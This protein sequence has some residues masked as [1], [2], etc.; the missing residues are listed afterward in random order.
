[1]KKITL[2]VFALA[3]LMS[4]AQEA[5]K[6]KEDTKLHIGANLQS[7]GTGLV[8]GMD[9]GLGENI[10]VGF[11]GNYLLGAT[12]ILGEK[13]DFK[14][15]VD[16]RARFN[17]NLGKVMNLPEQIDVYPGLDLGLKNF[18]A[19]LG[20]RYFFSD[21]FGLQAEVGFPLARYKSNISEFDYLNNQFHVN[22]SAVFNL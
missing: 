9:Y 12:E 17:A 13:P 15:R 7:G 6:G 2:I 11:T 10:S 4:N 16:V 3:G 22:L 21:G 18:G 5:Y 20:S 8:V 1:M 14:D 19:H